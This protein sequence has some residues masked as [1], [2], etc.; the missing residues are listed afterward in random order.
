MKICSTF[1]SQE[2]NSVK[3]DLSS[4]YVAQLRNLLFELGQL[5]FSS[6]TVLSIA[7]I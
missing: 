4:Y 1:D 5:S 2:Q 7:R 3:G 6:P